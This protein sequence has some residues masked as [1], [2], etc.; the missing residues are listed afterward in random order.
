MRRPQYL[1]YTCKRGCKPRL[2]WECACPIPVGAVVNRAYRGRRALPV[3]VPQ[4]I[5]PQLCPIKCTIQRFILIAYLEILI[6]HFR[7]VDVELIFIQQ[8]HQQRLLLCYVPD[9][10]EICHCV[11]GNFGIDIPIEER[12]PRH[13][14]PD[15]HEFVTGA[16]RLDA[17][18]KNGVVGHQFTG[19][20]IS[21]DK[22]LLCK[23]L[24]KP[25]C[26]DSDMLLQLL[27]EDKLPFVPPLHVC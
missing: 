1:P 14:A 17:R 9:G 5:T 25:L 18:D 16:R 11:F 3:L 2:P 10:D 12:L 7:E 19:E 22:P 27:D 15:L 26:A 24:F 21:L 23:D 8:L 13:L 6:L 20:E 4:T